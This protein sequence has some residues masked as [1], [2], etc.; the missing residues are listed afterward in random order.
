LE[1]KAVGTIETQ[2]K[3][4]K[5]DQPAKVRIALSI[6]IRVPSDS[7][8][9]KSRGIL[10]TCSKFCSPIEFFGGRFLK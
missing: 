3:N 4:P 9:P 8:T 5:Y 7:L 1:A 2:M 10:N 6:V